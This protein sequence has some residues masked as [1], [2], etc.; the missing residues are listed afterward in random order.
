[1][2]VCV[3]SAVGVGGKG[4]NVGG[5]V[6]VGNGGTGVGANWQ[7]ANPT[8]RRKISTGTTSFFTA[9]SQISLQPFN[10]CRFALANPDTQ[11]GQPI[12]D[13]GAPLHLMD[14]GGQ[15]ART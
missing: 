9:A 12:A 8:N 1:M 10:D 2:G 14:K 3:G 13:G 7:A 15:Y 4:V 11:R 5:G 6:A